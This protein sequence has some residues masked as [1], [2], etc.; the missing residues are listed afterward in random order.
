MINNLVS[1]KRDR[2]LGHAF[3]LALIILIN[4][5][6]LLN[7]T[8]SY[9][10]QWLNYPN[11]QEKYQFYLRNVAPVKN[12]EF[13]NELDAIAQSKHLL[14]SSVVDNDK[15][16]LVGVSGQASSSDGFTFANKKFVS[17]SDLN[18]LIKNQDD[19]ASIGQINGSINQLKAL[20]DVLFTRQVSIVKLASLINKTQTINATYSISGLTSDK[21]YSQIITKL[22]HLLHKHVNDLTN[23][24][25]GESEDASLLKDA[26]IIF[27]VIVWLLL[28]AYFV[29]FLLKQRKS[30]GNLM[31]LGWSKK[32]L[33]VKEYLS[34]LI[35]GIINVLVL[36]LIF[37]FGLLFKI[38]NLEIWQQFLLSGVFGLV[39]VTVAY[40]LASLVILSLKNVALIKGK[41]PKK[42]LYSFLISLYLISSAGLLAGAA[43]IDGPLK[44]IAT[45]AEQAK[46]WEK[47]A[48]YRVLANMKPG[49]DGVKAYTDTSSH[50]NQDVYHLYQAI[51]NKPGVYLVNSFYASKAW[52]NQSEMNQ[53]Y[54]HLLSKASWIITVSPNYLQKIGLKVPKVAINQAITGKRVFLMPKDLNNK[55]SQQFLKEYTTDGIS[56]GDIQ[57]TFVKKRQYRFYSYK[58][59]HA[60]FTWPIHT[61]EA[62]KTSSPIIDIV[63]P[64]NMT[65]V[66]IGNLLVPGLAGSLKLNNHR[67][68]NKKLLA[69][70]NLTDNQMTY[71]PVRKYID[72]L[73]KALWQTVTWFSSVLIMALIVLI[74]LLLSLVGLYQLLNQEEIAVKRML[75]FGLSQI[76]RLPLILVLTTGIL[77]LIISLLLH[78]KAAILTTVVAAILQI[79]AIMIFI[80]KNEQKQL[81]QYLKG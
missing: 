5:C 63:T 11:S 81:L 45:N 68:I 19:N 28:L 56:D 12:K 24:Y 51:E 36:S 41:L 39:L 61:K 34:F 77:E 1:K 10:K 23:N 78:S 22:A 53:S 54:N 69:K 4:L 66:D 6:L 27:S 75:G 49:N 33:L 58:A 40:L 20:P 44:S 29:T 13:A 76:Y 47:V 65:F 16:I 9:E 79:L 21:E 59:Q 74:F 31:L 14:I 43:Y 8:D 35:S 32:N 15:S 38:G 52:L 25:S 57:T 80:L 62:I 42:I 72:G 71:L 18:K 64:N 50:L 73:Q 67:I 3:I 17:A 70:Y 60:V 37:G 7:L 2:L 30:F 55:A 48:N 46:Q 26:V